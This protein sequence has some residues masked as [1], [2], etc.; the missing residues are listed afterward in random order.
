LEKFSSEYWDQHY[1]QDRAGWDIGYISTPLKTYFDQLKDKN[2]KILIPGAGNA[3][4]V[5][6]LFHQGFTNTHLL[7]F[8][9]Q[10]ILNFLSRCPD[11]PVNQIIKQDFFEH[12]AQYDLI[13]EQTFF[14]SIPPEKR[15]LYA[16]QVNDLLKPGGKLTGLLFSHEFEFAGPPF[17]G[18]EAAYRSLFS[19][20]FIIEILDIATNSIKPRQNRELFIKLRKKSA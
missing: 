19:E 20:H 14:S 10:S 9:D 2:L 8:S 13:V 5:E 17:G 15:H 4:E 6:Y 7:D 18:T 11:F 1:T 12:H 3:Y 16:Q